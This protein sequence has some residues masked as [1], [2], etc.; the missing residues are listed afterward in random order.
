MWRVNIRDHHEGY[1]TSDKYLQNRERLDKNRTNSEDTLLSG[2]ARERLALLQG[3]LLCGCCGRRLTVRY[4]GIHPQY[5]CNWRRR[6]GVATK[7]C[8]QIQAQCVNPAV[9]AV[10]L[11][12]IAPAKLEPAVE[13]VRQLEEHDQAVGQQWQRRIERADYKFQLAQRRYEEVDPSN[14]LVASTL[15]R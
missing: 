11:E 9:C 10:V 5:E 13:S 4:G 2:V 15:E 7:A 6:E 14:R 8:M 12:A 3:M 1:I